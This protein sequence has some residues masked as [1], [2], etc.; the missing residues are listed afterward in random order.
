MWLLL[1]RPRA[2]TQRVRP[3]RQPFGVDPVER[4]GAVARRTGHRIVSWETD[5]DAGLGASSVE[6]GRRREGDEVGRQLASLLAIVTRLEAD[7]EHGAHV[8][9]TGHDGAGQGLQ[10]GSGVRG[11]VHLGRRTF[12]RRLRFLG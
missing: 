4:R 2:G 5:G 10:L 1:C 9:H 8:G 7:E 12:E 11:R 6:L 3:T